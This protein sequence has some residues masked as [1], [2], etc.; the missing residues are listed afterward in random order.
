MSKIVAIADKYNIDFRLLPAIAMQESNLCK[1]DP[2][3][4]L[5]TA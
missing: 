2:R 3:Q 5:T 1:S 4:V